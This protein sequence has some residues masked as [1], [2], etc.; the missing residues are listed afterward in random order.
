MSPSAVDSDAK[1]VLIIV[2][3]AMPIM[4]AP[5]VIAVRRGLRD[6]LRRPSLPG[7]D[8]EKPGRAR[9]RAGG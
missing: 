5:A 7:T 4:T 1:I 2:M 9:R 6:E 8:Q 3:I